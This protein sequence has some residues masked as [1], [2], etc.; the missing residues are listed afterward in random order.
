M[1]TLLFPFLKIAGSRTSNT[2][3]LINRSSESGHPHLVPEFN[4]KAFS[5]SFFELYIGHGEENTGKTFSGKNHNNIFLG[6]SP[7]GTKIKIN[8]WYLIKLTGFV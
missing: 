4:T 3:L 1:Y 5:F 8:N 6:Q 7:K 2:T